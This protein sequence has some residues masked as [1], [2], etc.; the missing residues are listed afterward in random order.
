MGWRWRDLA[1]A[2][3]VRSPVLRAAVAPGVL[4]IVLASH[5]SLRASSDATPWKGG[6]FGMFST[7][8]S[9]GTRIVRVE[10]QSDL[11]AVP[12]AVPDRLEDQV[13]GVRAA[14]STG[15]LVR[16]GEALAAQRWAVPR[17][18]QDAP[19]ASPRDE[20][21]HELAVEALSRVVPVE[22]V[23]AVDPARFDESRHRRLDVHAVTV[24]VLRLEAGT[25][26]GG[27]VLRPRVIRAVNLDLGTPAGEAER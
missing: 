10:L 18:A 14:P 20:A 21:L 15:R 8:D 27:D 19:S 7:I 26:P 6:G 23:Q 24:A 9:P 13:A 16:L 25:G 2:G 17:L 12:V 1:R 11:G 4:L 3:A 22:A 5:V